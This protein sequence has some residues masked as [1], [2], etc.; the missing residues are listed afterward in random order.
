MMLSYG[1]SGS[2]KKDFSAIDQTLISVLSGK[3][4]A[5][6][7]ATGFLGSLLSRLVIWANDELGIDARLLLCVR[8]AAKLDVIMPGVSAR[9]DVSVVEVDFSRPC[10]ALSVDFDYLVHTA[11][12]TASKIMVK[13]PADVLNITING[14]RWA[15]DSARGISSS[16]TLFISSMEACG[17]FDVP[18]NVYEGTLG[19]INMNS[20]RSCYPEGKRVGELMCLAYARQYGTY[21]VAG[22]LAQTFGAGVLPSEGRVFKQFAASAMAGE[23]I[24]LHTDGM[25]EG[26]YVYS[27]DALSAI[28]LLLAKGNKGETYNI[29]NEACHTTIRGMAQM[30][31]DRFGGDGCSVVI[32]DE[33]SSKFGYAE[34]T[35]MTLRS[36]KLR[37][38][39]W[40]P[41]VDLPGAYARL[42]A[43]LNEAYEGVM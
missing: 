24:V 15:L 43:Y 31:A 29:A 7:G 13:R 2:L 39:G 17:S 12:V 26:N 25:S 9:E 38:L 23:P 41:T 34:P 18:T 4:L 40:E 10:E 11:A 14:T 16:K 32:E 21:A 30:V 8:N 27:A 36:E 20:V 19:A 1:I 6:S 35:K 5:V 22:R 42:I 3:V 28:L 37:A 33:D